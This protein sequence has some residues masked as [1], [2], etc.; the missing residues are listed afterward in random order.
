MKKHLDANHSLGQVQYNVYRLD[1]QRV[2]LQMAYTHWKENMVF[3]GECLFGMGFLR[4]GF[5]KSY[6]YLYIY[7]KA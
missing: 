1:F 7:I 5:V 6:L 4:H 2:Q 3:N